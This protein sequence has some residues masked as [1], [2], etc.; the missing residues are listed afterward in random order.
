MGCSAVSHTI[1]DSVSAPPELAADTFVEKLVYIP[2]VYQANDYPLDVCICGSLPGSDSLAGLCQTAL[3]YTHKAS[4]SSAWQHFVAQHTR[5]ARV[6]GRF[7]ATPPLPTLTGAEPHFQ[8]IDTL[9][10]SFHGVHKWEPIVFGAWMRILSRT[11]NT[12][13][14]YLNLRNDSSVKSLGENAALHGL[15]PSRLFP[16]SITGWE[17]HLARLGGCDILLDTLVYGAH[18]TT[19]DALWGGVPVLTMNGWGSHPLGKMPGKVASSLMKHLGL[20]S[21]IVHSLKDYEEVAVLY[22]RGQGVR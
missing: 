6:L 19:A 12:A 20:Q 17:S 15:H 13:L 22:G 21:T 7:G 8:K 2:T 10:C 9:Y 5:D 16:F 4:N 11:T 3:L 1:L 18:T 14:A